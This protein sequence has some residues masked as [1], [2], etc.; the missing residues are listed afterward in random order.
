MIIAHENLQQEAEH[1]VTTL[2]Q[3][4]G[5]S[6]SL[7][8]CNFDRVFTPHPV[9]PGFLESSQRMSAEIANTF[10]GE[11]VLV[12]TPRD[13]YAGAVSQENEWVLGYQ[14]NNFSLISTARIKG[15]DNKP[16]NS[17]EVPLDKYLKRIVTMTIHEI[18][19]EVAKAEHHQM[20]KWVTTNERYSLP[21]G[22]HCTDNRCVMY[23]VVDIKTPPR[24]E[25]FML[26]GDERRYDAGLDEHIERI[27]SAWFCPKCKAAIKIPEEYFK[28]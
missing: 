4:Y 11:K 26:L 13:I 17:L 21:L 28:I 9:W 16:R 12:V 3:V 10:P 14:H 5:F 27:Y 7:I 23:E 1:L 15:T 2:N 25:G 19:H 18:G 20:A 22:P 8:N 6:S 24:E